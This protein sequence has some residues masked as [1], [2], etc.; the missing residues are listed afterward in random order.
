MIYAKKYIAS[1]IFALK[2]MCKCFVK[3]NYNKCKMWGYHG[4]D[5]PLCMLK[6]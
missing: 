1:L 2:H 4:I 5:L 6:N 3:C